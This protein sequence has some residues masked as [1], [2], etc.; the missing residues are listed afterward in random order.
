MHLPSTTPEDGFWLASSDNSPDR[1][2]TDG[3]QSQ[4]CEWAYWAVH[5][6]TQVKPAQSKT[7]MTQQRNQWAKVWTRSYSI[8]GS[9]RVWKI[10]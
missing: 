4:L 2:V 1:E 6:S 8:D 7:V 10:P 5:L 3:P 9:Q